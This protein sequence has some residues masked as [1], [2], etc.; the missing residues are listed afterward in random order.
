MSM[1][2][3]LEKQIFD[4][5]DQRFDGIGSV[6]LTEGNTLIVRLRG[7]CGSCPMRELSCEMD[8]RDAILDSFPAVQN[9]SVQNHNISKETLAFARQLLGL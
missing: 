9:V 8:I 2:E 3:H 1:S 6:E 4:F 7:E 5:L